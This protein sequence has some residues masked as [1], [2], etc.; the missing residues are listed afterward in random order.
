MRHSLSK[1]TAFN[2][3]TTLRHTFFFSDSQCLPPGDP[4][5]LSTKHG[6]L[7]TE[8]SFIV[9]NRTIAYIRWP[10]F[11]IKTLLISQIQSTPFMT[12]TVK[13]GTLPASH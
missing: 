13:L 5:I 11:T 6:S 4:R 12:G 8:K 1:D 3:K 7:I 2:G 10:V 9:Q